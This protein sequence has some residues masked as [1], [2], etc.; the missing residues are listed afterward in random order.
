LQAALEEEGLVKSTVILV[1]SDH[2]EEF[3]EHGGLLH[4]RTQY[5]ELVRVPLILLGPGIPQGK[6]VRN[7]VSLVDIVPTL[8]GLVGIDASPEVTGMNLA[9]LWSEDPPDISSRYLYAGNDHSNAKDNIRSSVRQGSFK[10]HHDRL[11]QRWAL[12]ELTTDPRER[13]DVSSEHPEVTQRL[14][15]ELE[16]FAKKNWESKTIA[17]LSAEDEAK[18]RS[19]GYLQ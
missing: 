12:H 13:R 7:P 15:A 14:R 5:E 6:K 2:G 3:M 17:P 9:S 8:L 4:G 18:L 19:L 1:T 10:L 16:A 11:E